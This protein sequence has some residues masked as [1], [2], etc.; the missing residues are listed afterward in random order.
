MGRV[1][2]KYG[3]AVWQK[4]AIAIFIVVALPH[5]SGAATLT[6]Q[7]S[8]I[9]SVPSTWGGAVPTAADSVFV[10]SDHVIHILSNANCKSLA[11]DCDID[12]D[13]TLLFI[14]PG[15]TLTVSE[16]VNLSS[17]AGGT[18]HVRVEGTFSAQSDI[19]FNTTDPISTLLKMTYEGGLLEIGGNFNFLPDGRI[20]SDSVTESTIKFIGTAQQVLPVSSNIEYHDIVFSNSSAGGVVLASNLD[21][22]S[23]YGDIIIENGIFNNKGFLVAGNDSTFQIMSGGTYSL[24][25]TTILPQGFKHVFDAGSTIRY[26]GAKQNV[27][28]PN[29]NQHY[30][31]LVVSGSN[32]KILYD[33]ID[34]DGY[35]SIEGF[36]LDAN[37]T[38][39]YDINILGAW[40]N[41]GGYFVARQGRVAFK[42][43][44]QQSVLSYNQPFY[45][46]EINNQSTTGI[47][48]ADNMIISNSLNLQDGVVLT[49]TDTINITNSSSASVYGHSENSFVQG[50]LTRFIAFNDAT[51]A[52][53][54]GNGST[55]NNYYLAEIENDYMTGVQKITGKF[56]SLINHN[57]A[58]MSVQ[59]AWLIYNKIF[60][61]GVWTLEPDVQPT[62]GFYHAK[63]FIGN[64]SGMVDNLFGLLK[65]PHGSTTGA[66]WSHGNGTLNPANG[67]GR[68][69]SHG[70]ALRKGLKSFSEFGGGGGGGGPLPIELL[71]F[72]A[73]VTEHGVALTWTTALEIDNDY[74]TIERSVDGVDFE[75]VKTIDG[76]GNSAI[77]R[78][79][80]DLDDQP[81]T[82][83]S[84]YRLK[85][86][87]F[88]GRFS[89]SP[90][91]RV[92]VLESNVMIEL[93][94]N[95]YP[96]PLPKG[97]QLQIDF[98]SGSPKK[99]ELLIEFYDLASGKKIHTAY[100]DGSNGI[101]NLPDKFMPGLYLLRGFSD[102]R[103]FNHKLMIQ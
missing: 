32:K 14:Y 13:A 79:Y 36:S 63:L 10:A 61:E 90:I 76:A 53:P 93:N 85:Q 62:S 56:G 54:L 20:L 50:I 70:Y 65:R 15:I 69:V 26:D 60:P 68:L 71:N 97:S 46:V 66:D 95:L 101:V 21:S 3:K 57:N 11:V 19:N 16:D 47:S 4:V 73:D 67:A 17:V 31:N 45:D 25:G 22:S 84:Y 96:N 75:V 40:L 92:V 102:S 55:T 51:Y 100:L 87:D 83:E 77:T 89:Y 82:G 86:T 38:F 43:S 24:E 7:Q 44:A 88:D 34:I 42:G 8:G 94:A 72:N 49:G 6:S 59:D 12:A 74:F 28:A 91:V 78:H 48:L 81:V 52:F 58:D 30:Y 37:Y 98:N 29:N 80:A 39:N 41:S 33:D 18:L 99:E 1:L 5:F 23:L 35:L 64:F 2:R 9:W 27:Y 103:T